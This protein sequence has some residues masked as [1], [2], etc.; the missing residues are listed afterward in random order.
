M[1][2][3]DYH[4]EKFSTDEEDPAASWDWYLKN[5]QGPVGLSFY[6]EAFH[7][8]A[9]AQNVGKF[10]IVKFTSS[11]LDYR[12]T[13]RHIRADDGEPGYRLLVPLH[14]HFRFEQ[15]DSRE[16]FHPGKPVFFD[17]RQRLFMS[18]D[19]PISAAILHI[20]EGSLDDT[21]AANAP[22]ALDERRAL[23]RSLD[24]QV[25]LLVEADGWTATDFSI[26]Y[27]NVLSTLGGVLNPSAEDK[28]GARAPL[29]ERAR[30]FIEEHARDRGVTPAVIAEKLGT[31]EPTLYR[32]MQ[33]A[34]Y[35]S[36]AAML[37]QIRVERAHRRLSKARPVDMDKIAFE[38]G[39]PSTRRFRE[40]YREHYGRTP[41]ETREQLFGSTGR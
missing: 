29:A 39:F 27:D 35:S 38:E 13:H 28:S 16:I 31:S 18:H 21:L 11:A 7:S 14:G 30:R 6:S 2:D 26:A 32:A 10:Q 36:P 19:G 15:G 34:G 8:E 12:R 41:A 22:L 23:V 25:R 9:V 37:R 1:T 33:K 40:A 3:A 4:K 20:P 24:A 5:R 17:W